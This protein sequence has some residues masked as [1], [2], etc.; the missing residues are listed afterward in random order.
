MRINFRLA[1]PVRNLAKSE[2]MYRQGLGLECLGRFEDHDGF[3]GVML[4]TAG[5]DFHFEFTHC[6]THPVAPTPTVEDLMVFYVP[7]RSA[8]LARCQAMLDAG[9]V[10][11]QSFNPYWARD[12]KTFVDPDGYRVV[13]QC[14]SWTSVAQHEA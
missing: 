8:W 5:G 14:E 13:I 7:D 1:L 2:T 4:G 11:V 9:F 10:E 6:R 3:D 12:G